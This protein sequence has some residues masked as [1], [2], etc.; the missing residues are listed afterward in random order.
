M[1]CLSLSTYIILNFYLVFLLTKFWAFLYHDLLYFS[2]LLISL[3]ASD[4]LPYIPYCFTVN[5][6]KKKSKKAKKKNPFKPQKSV[7][8]IHL[9]HGVISSAPWGPLCCCFWFS[10]WRRGSDVWVM[11][12]GNRDS[13]RN[14]IVCR[15]RDRKPGMTAFSTFCWRTE[16][17]ATKP[18]SLLTSLLPLHAMK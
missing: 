16:L 10:E 5:D 2:F 12:I 1:L 8:F 18:P 14:V 9:P 17:K 13:K 4:V 6:K 3:S 11:F 7:Y 15:N